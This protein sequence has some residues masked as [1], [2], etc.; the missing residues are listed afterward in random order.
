MSETENDEAVAASLD[1][2]KEGI[3]NGERPKLRAYFARHRNSPY[4]ETYLIGLICLYSE[5]LKQSG[6]QPPCFTAL[7]R[8]LPDFRNE[9]VKLPLDDLEP[10]HLMPE[11]IKGYRITRFLSK[12]GQGFVYEA[13]S[14][15][16]V[17][18]DDDDRKGGVPVV[19]KF[20]NRRNQDNDWLGLEGEHLNKLSSTAFPSFHGFGTYR[21][22][23]FIAMSKVDADP[24][25]SWLE[26]KDWAKKLKVTIIKQLAFAVVNMHENKIVHRD[27]SPQNIMIS[28][29]TFQPVIFDFGLA[30]SMDVWVNP[31]CKIDYEKMGSGGTLGFMPPEQATADPES[32]G[33]KCDVFQLGTLLLY[34]FEGERL[35]AGADQ[36]ERLENTIAYRINESAVTKFRKENPSLAPILDRAIARDPKM[37]FRTAKEFARAL[38]DYESSMSPMSQ[39]WFRRTSTIAWCAA[40]LL[41]V[42]LI[43]SLLSGNWS[44][45]QNSDRI[46]KQFAA[47]CRDNNI[48]LTQ[49]T[50]ENF[51]IE[52]E[53]HKH[54]SN[55]LPHSDFG[56]R[57]ELGPRFRFKFNHNPAVKLFP[58]FRVFPREWKAG[59][60]DVVRDKNWD[61]LTYYG[62][63]H[64]SD[65]D[66]QGPL[67]VSLSSRSY[68]DGRYVIG[69]FN[70]DKDIKQAIED[71]YTARELQEIVAA[72][73]SPVLDY[74][75][76]GRYAHIGSWQL[77]PKM[78]EH[79]YAFSKIWLGET[80]GSLDR[81]INLL[82]GESGST[83]KL[84]WHGKQYYP[85]E[86]NRQ[87][88]NALRGLEFAPV[89]YTKVEWVD[90][91]VSKIRKHRRSGV[92]LSSETKWSVVQDLMEKME[93][94]NE[95]TSWIQTTASSAVAGLHLRFGEAAKYI[96]RIEYGASP[97]EL[98]LSA[99]VKFK[100]VESKN[101][102]DQIH[103]SHF[104]PA[105]GGF[106][107]NVVDKYPQNALPVPAIWKDVYFKVVGKNG[108]RSKAFRVKPDRYSPGLRLICEDKDAPIVYLCGSSHEHRLLWYSGNDDLMDMIWSKGKDLVNVGYGDKHLLKEIDL[109]ELDDDLSFNFIRKNGSQIGPFK[110][111]YADGELRRIFAEK[112]I[113]NDE[114]F[115]LVAISFVNCTEQSIANYDYRQGNNPTAKV[116]KHLLRAGTKKNQ[117]TIRGIFAHPLYELASN[118]YAWACLSQ[119]RIGK[120]KSSTAVAHDINIPMKLL[121]SG[122]K[123]GADPLFVFEVPEDF[124]DCWV[125][126]VYFDG[127]ES[128]PFLIKASQIDMRL[129]KKRH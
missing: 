75:L 64:R 2:Y 67:Q 12:G 93:S 96:D 112:A 22:R 71:A 25:I 53:L 52:V 79:R 107:W 33:V 92:E 41:F 88:G 5:S 122:S 58:S 103:K 119:I 4:R 124:T 77:H 50:K 84:S 89:V 21:D 109:K 128:E 43:I 121:I 40:G 66:A 31:E 69:P 90:G 9:V 3:E 91:T 98:E 116:L 24:F 34:A 100:Y 60:V 65:L 29:H 42:A 127:T 7:C 61:G 78:L 44:A 54:T 23:P 27:L 125:Q 10:E 37:R 48:D 82:E 73:E 15:S 14:L 13:Q 47:L 85:D 97:N 32:V 106:V 45:D 17:E 55:L 49:I 95:L 99:R 72:K 6:R 76:E 110:Y 59:L 16:S 74:R 111:Q 104:V 57:S 101:E 105:D 18:D 20:S 39:P 126:F 62:N 28:K 38:E 46:P 80:E 63:I 1:E 83:K 70:F 129:Y 114:R 56:I 81:Y 87:F 94:R 30:V 118:R 102:L 113:L 120:T 86:V 51:E 117:K 26:L 108:E 8:E 35:F 36:A 19:I 11:H 115:D 123:L 68:E